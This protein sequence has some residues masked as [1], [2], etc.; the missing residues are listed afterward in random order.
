MSGPEYHRM[1]GFLQANFATKELCSLQERSD[2]QLLLEN[3]YKPE[4][5][6]KLL[7]LQTFRYQPQ[8][9]DVSRFTGQID[10]NYI[11]AL[12]VFV[13]IKISIMTDMET[14]PILWRR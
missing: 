14:Q 3:H 13:R 1:R 11:L 5:K 6:T 9:H 12:F 2:A 8:L 7:E 10:E 4:K